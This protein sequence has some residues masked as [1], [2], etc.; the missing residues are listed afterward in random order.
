[1][2]YLLPLVISFGL[3]YALVP[4]CRWVSRWFD[5]LD[6]PGKH[7][8]HGRP[9]PLFG[10]IAVFAGV[11]GSI[12]V[13]V[14]LDWIQWGSQ[15]Q[16]ILLG[17]GLVLLMGF[18]D[19]LFALPPQLKFL[20]QLLATVVIVVHGVFLSLFVGPGPFVYGLTVLWVV[21]ITNSFN[22]LDNMDGL[23]AGVAAI[24]AFIFT[25]NSYRQGDPETMILSVVL[26]GS[27]LAFLRFNFEPADIFLGDTGSGF[28]G[29]YLG[30]LSVAANY[31]EQSDLQQLPIITPILIFSVPLFDTFSVIVLRLLEGDSVWEAD[32]RHFSHRLVGL[33]L[34]RSSAVLLIYLLTFTVGS[35]ALLLGRVNINDALLI[36]VHAVAL[37]AIIVILEYASATG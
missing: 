8:T 18:F 4:I 9:T 32:N 25:V 29:F 12:F 28:I 5:L 16:G 26:V 10:G 17:S 19:D 7:K 14:Y 33:G 35:L 15:L 36:L 2:H 24:C 21:G 31:L 3:C 27:L 6:R 30:A 23:A 13:W 20:V 34:D 37:F 11:W 1:M 22:L